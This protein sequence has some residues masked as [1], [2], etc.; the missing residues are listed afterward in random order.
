M[1]SEEGI[2]LGRKEREV[3]KG[4][5]HGKW[6]RR[7]RTCSKR[8]WEMCDKI[9]ESCP[10]LQPKFVNGY[11]C[12]RMCIF[13]CVHVCACEWYLVWN[14]GFNTYWAGTMSLSNA[15]SQN[16]FLYIH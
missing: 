9:S 15:H 13:L 8:S 12:V 10:A 11:F 7:R 2:L 4:V 16:M 6:E 5:L 14:I 3:N 1:D